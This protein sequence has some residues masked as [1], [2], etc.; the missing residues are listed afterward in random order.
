MTDRTDHPWFTLATLTCMYRSFFVYLGNPL[1]CVQILLGLPWQPSQEV[2]RGPQPRHPS[3][4]KIIT[5]LTLHITFTLHKYLKVAHIARKVGSLYKQNT[6]GY[7][8]S[9]DL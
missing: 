5:Q 6:I 8:H 4:I 1:L 9:N 7:Q 2:C 3:K